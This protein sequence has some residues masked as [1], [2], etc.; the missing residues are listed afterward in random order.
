MSYATLLVHMELDRPNTGLLK[1]TAELAERFHAGVVGIAARQPLQMVF[2]DGYVSGDVYQQDR[3][4]IVKELKAAEAEFRAAL[5]GRVKFLEWRSAQTYAYLADYFA[6]EARCA[7]IV[8]TGV[9][10]GDFLDASH[11]VNTGELI[12]Q[13]GRPVSIVPTTAST[14]K[15]DHVLV[16]WKDTRETR[17]AVSD[18]LPLLKQAAQVSVVEIAVEEEQAAAAEHVRDVAAW[19]QRHGVRAEGSVL[20]STGDD[21]TALYAFGQDAGTNVVVAG[22]YG[23]SRIREWVLGGVT[24]DLLLSANRCSLVSH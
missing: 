1:V 23:H 3:V 18:A 6:G 20:L 16:G 2:G 13:T 24:R 10:T 9:A 7:D 15:L 21:A 11:A 17:R 19:L 14:L 8:L 4:E 22:A 5:Q 12:M